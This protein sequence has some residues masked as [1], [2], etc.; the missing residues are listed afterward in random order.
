[1]S[2]CHNTDS[3]GFIYRAETV[4]LQDKTYLEPVDCQGRNGCRHCSCLFQKFGRV[5]FDR[6]PARR[7]LARSHTMPERAHEPLVLPTGIHEALAKAPFSAQTFPF[8][9]KNS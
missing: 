6:F 5:F 3:G 2:F 9:T 8:F 1:M 7:V 4:D